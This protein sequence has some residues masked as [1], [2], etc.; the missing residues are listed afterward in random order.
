MYVPNSFLFVVT[1]LLL[2]HP[3]KREHLLQVTTRSR[4]R[5][6]GKRCL[7]RLSSTFVL[8]PLTASSFFSRHP[9]AGEGGRVLLL[10]AS[11]RDFIHDVDSGHVSSNLPTLV[12]RRAIYSQC[13]LTSSPFQTPHPTPP[14]CSA[15]PAAVAGD[16]AYDASFGRCKARGQAC[17][18]LPSA[19]SIP[20]HAAAR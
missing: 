6:A 11:S 4:P 3:V 7:S 13:K 19:P 10:L 16:V 9:V 2:K 8:F 14:P 18:W 12:F 20:A 17:P 1:L 15:E 5:W